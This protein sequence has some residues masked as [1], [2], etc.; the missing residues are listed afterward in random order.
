MDGEVSQCLRFT[1]KHHDDLCICFSI[2]H[3]SVK[4]VNQVM[5]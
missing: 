1:R 5:K 3:G 2:K 4:V